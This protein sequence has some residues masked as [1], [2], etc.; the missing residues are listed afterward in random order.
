MG[1]CI[2][3]E[4]CSYLHVLASPDTPSLGNDVHVTPGRTASPSPV[5]SNTVSSYFP[6]T[7]P[8][9]RVPPTTPVTARESRSDSSGMDVEPFDL[10][11]SAFRTP[12]RTR[13]NSAE[14]SSDMQTP[15]SISSGFSDDP[16][17]TPAGATEYIHPFLRSSGSS[18]RVPSL[19]TFPLSPL[20]PLSHSHAQPRDY[21]SA[22]AATR[23]PVSLD[24]MNN[25]PL[26]P[27]S[28]LSSQPPPLSMS[29]YSSTSSVPVQIVHVPFAVPMYPEVPLSSS[30]NPHGSSASNVSTPRRISV[31]TPQK[32]PPQPFRARGR[33]FSQPDVSAVPTSPESLLYRSE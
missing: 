9:H 23:G 20:S 26:T 8:L 15:S 3:G 19:P 12:V 22:K 14:T 7:P 24:C 30:A 32:S 4:R 11:A 25:L 17:M 27:L 5:R 2:Y 33:A 18:N 10:D 13:F 21:L 6:T 16:P 31:S 29:M 1:K 28:P